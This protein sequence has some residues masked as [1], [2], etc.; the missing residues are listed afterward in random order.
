M[1][2]K[3]Y[4]LTRSCQEK[5]CRETSTYEYNTKKDYMDGEARYRKKKWYCNRH[6]PTGEN[7]KDFGEKTLIEQYVAER[8]EQLDKLFWNGTN[9]FA[10]G[11]KWNAHADDFPSGTKIT[12]ETKITVSPPGEQESVE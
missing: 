11:K 12:V 8:D 7:L 6:D 10:S 1:T 3:T 4:N 9:G 2:Q 5:G